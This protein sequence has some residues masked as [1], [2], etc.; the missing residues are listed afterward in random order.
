MKRLRLEL[1]FI[2]IERRRKRWNLYFL[3]ATEDP[4]DARQTV[5]TIAPSHPIR[6]HPR[7][8]NRIDFEPKGD[9]GDLNGLF[10]LER[11]MPQDA[12]IKARLWVVQCRDRN[13]NLGEVLQQVSGADKSDQVISNLLGGAMPW[14]TVGKSIMDVADI[15]GSFFE[16]SK[17]AKKGFV[18]MDQSF[19]GLDMEDGE[20][21]R[22]NRLSGFGDIGW[23]WIVS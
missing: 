18:S 19:I 10:I 14:Y 13:R 2:E 23:T 11:D 12:S 22:T 5:I 16:K 15:V 1:D 7:D 21:D 20:F 17:D 8:E 3:I 4:Q 9:A 6:L